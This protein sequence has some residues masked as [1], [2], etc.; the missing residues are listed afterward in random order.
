MLFRVVRVLIQMFNSFFYYGVGVISFFFFPSKVG[1]GYLAFIGGR[2][3][4]CRFPTH[5]T[6][7]HGFSHSRPR[8]TREFFSLHTHFRLYFETG[9]PIFLYPSFIAW[10]GLPFT[11]SVLRYEQRRHNPLIVT[12]PLSFGTRTL[13]SCSVPGDL[14]ILHY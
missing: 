7:F 8:G 2:S 11:L 4:A 3:R 1:G 9:D 6:R 12:S 14:R 13:V 5:S 10:V